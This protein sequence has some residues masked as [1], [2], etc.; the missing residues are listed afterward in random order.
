MEIFNSPVEI[1]EWSRRQRQ[2]DHSIGFVPTMGALHDGHSTLIKASASEHSRNVASIFVNPLQFND[3]KDLT[4][5]PRTLEA[6]IEIA[7]AA[8][9][10][11]LYVPSV[12]AMYPDGFS[13]KI[14]AGSLSDTMEGAHRPGHFDGM[15]TVVVKLLNTVQPH[16][17][18]FGQKDFQQL[19]IIRH[20]V[21]DLNIKCAI[22]AVPTVRHPDGLAMSSRNTRL[23]PLHRQQ[24]PV[25]YSALQKHATQSPFRSV[26]TTAIKQQ[27]TE[28]IQS[29][30]E[31]RV[32]YI[33][34][35]KSDSLTPSEYFDRSCTICVAVWFG[36]VRLIDNISRDT[37]HD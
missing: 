19:A 5:Y 31:G 25:I 36:D 35:V 34:I 37:N 8:G 7:K 22:T 17:A 10:D 29:A 2:A 15:A 9:I 16:T 14:S 33:E 1:S 4:A 27:F 11:A 13:A 21:A 32:E 26:A 28:E 30:S 6:D 23:T 24:S 18:Y 3:P 12:S 20:V